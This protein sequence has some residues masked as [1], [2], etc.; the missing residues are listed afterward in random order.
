M[1]FTQGKELEAAEIGCKFKDRFVALNPD[2]E[3]GDDAEI[4]NNPRRMFD[5]PIR[6]KPV[7]VGV[8]IG[9]SPA[10]VGTTYNAPDDESPCCERTQSSPDKPCNKWICGIWDKEGT[11]AQEKML[12]VFDSLFGPGY[13]REVLLE[14]PSFDACPVRANEADQ[15][16]T[17]MWRG[18][19]D[20]FYSVLEH[21]RPSLIICN[22]NSKPSNGKSAWGALLENCD[23]DVRP[24]KPYTN[25]HGHGFLKDADIM[26]GPLKGSKVIGLPQLT[27][28][29]TNK[30]WRKLGKLGAELGLR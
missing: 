11:T 19:M 23:Y 14:T 1:T 30:L 28:W 13:G 2:H 22:R 27:Y 4:W 24:N 5:D 21:L 10:V 12:R 7:L 17:E 20:W 26:A 3:I 18:S 15:I 29:G 16:P 8:H 6:G 25:I 9:G